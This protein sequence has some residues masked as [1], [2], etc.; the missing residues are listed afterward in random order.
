M[1]PTRSAPL[2]PRSVRT[3][4][5]APWRQRLTGQYT[6]AWDSP[7]GPQRLRVHNRLQ[8]LEGRAP[9]WSS[10]L[11]LPRTVATYLRTRRHALLREPLPFLVWDTIA[12]L[13]RE[14]RP[15]ARVLEVGAGNS[16]LWYLR[17]GALVTSFEHSP[18]WVERL[19][20]HVEETLGAEVA[21]R[22]D[23]RLA[24]GDEAIAG[25]AALPDEHFDLVVVDSKNEH[26]ERPAAVDAA[27]SKLHA[28]G[29]MVLDDSDN[30]ANWP[31]VERMADRERVRF[32]GYGPMCA[33]VCQTSLWQV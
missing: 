21:Q 18:E 4:Y 13:E 30:P 24:E 16:T 10:A 15:G 28:G 11:R 31:A 5:T 25:I 8:D 1:T 20:R 14:L 33:V 2:D 32:T 26:I 22:L 7:D 23:L 3:F 29:W 27:R 17:Q 6:V 19:Q 9:S 12:F